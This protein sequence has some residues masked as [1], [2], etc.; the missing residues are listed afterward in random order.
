MT[1]RLSKSAYARRRGVTEGAVRQAI[2]AGRISIGDDGK[3]DPELA[4]VEWEQNTNP[5][6][7]AGRKSSK[8][9]SSSLHNAKTAH[10]VLKAQTA[11]V[12]LDK[13]KGSLIDRDKALAHVFKLARSER[14]SWLN[15][16]A[17]VSAEL[18]S[19]L[20]ADENQV[21]SLLTEY[22]TRHLKE[23]SE[24]KPRLE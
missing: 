1:T 12:N 15:F 13:L 8:A 17:R 7:T 24:L 23:L 19:K 21:Y 10:E 20:N 2:K 18:A 11:K 9:E 14:D 5:G 4:D 22:I 3:I 6:Y 16:P